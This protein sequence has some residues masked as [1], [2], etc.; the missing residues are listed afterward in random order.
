MKI[1]NT[2]LPE[3]I[4]IEP[5]VHLDSRGL[6]YENWNRNRYAELGIPSEFAQDNLSRSNQG[7]LRGLHIQHPNAQG[8][9]ISVLEGEIFDVAVDLRTNSPTFKK[10]V[11]VN[12]SSKNH[13]QLWIPKGFAHGFLVLSNSALVSYKASDFYSPEDEMTILW[14]DPQIKIDWPMKTPDLS[15][16]DLRGKLLSEVPLEKLPKI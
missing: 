13:H 14:N 9:L 3:V 4:I 6:F 16:K 11:S 8:K 1:I 12:L 15:E 10:W 2:S 7:V 5:K